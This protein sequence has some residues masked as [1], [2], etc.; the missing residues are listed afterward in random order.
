MQEEEVQGQSYVFSLPASMQADI[1]ASKFLEAT[2]VA[3]LHGS[4][5]FGISYDGLK[6]VAATGALLKPRHQQFAS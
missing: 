1:T 5:L 4:G 2:Q 3:S 6:D